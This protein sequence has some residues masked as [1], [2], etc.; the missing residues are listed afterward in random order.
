MHILHK[1]RL[2]QQNIAQAKAVLCPPTRLMVFGSICSSRENSRGG[3]EVGRLKEHSEVVPKLRVPGPYVL[4]VI[5]KP[6]SDRFNVCVFTSFLHVLSAYQSFLPYH[7]LLHL[8]LLVWLLVITLSLIR[9]ML[10]AS[11]HVSA[12]LGADV[13]YI[14]PYAS[15]VSME[16]FP[17]RYVCLD[18][19]FYI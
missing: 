10:L 13:L 17:Q 14:R 8:Y 5:S 16:P 15:R 1:R 3:G 6:Y 4:H 18:S 12:R 7:G 11:S 9:G 2:V 19:F